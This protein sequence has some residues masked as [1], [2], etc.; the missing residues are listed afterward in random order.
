M[1][2]KTSTYSVPALPREDGP[3]AAYY[4]C[5]IVGGLPPPSG[6]WYPPSTEPRPYSGVQIVSGGSYLYLEPREAGYLLGLLSSR[7]GSLAQQ[8]RARL[9]A[10]P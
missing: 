9:E 8:L 4:G 2:V 3:I 5:S 7:K 10:L 6:P 1:K